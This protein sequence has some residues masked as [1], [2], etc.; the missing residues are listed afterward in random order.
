DSLPTSQLRLMYGQARLRKYPGTT[1]LH[2]TTEE[3][4]GM[5]SVVITFANAAS[6]KRLTASGA[7][8]AWVKTA[9]TCEAP[10]SRSA[11]AAPANVRPVLAIS[12]TITHGRFLTSPRTCSGVAI[13]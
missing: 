9:K 7:N 8:T 4:I 5:L 3:P 10:A 12:S 6:R 11:C 1:D 13:S 2:L